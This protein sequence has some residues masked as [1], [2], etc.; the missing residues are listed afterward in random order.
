MDGHIRH[1]DRLLPGF[2]NL[3]Y[4]IGARRSRLVAVQVIQFVLDEV[5]AGSIIHP[6]E[7]VDKIQLV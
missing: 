1:V 6:A 7:V 5:A 2:R 4:P 3:A